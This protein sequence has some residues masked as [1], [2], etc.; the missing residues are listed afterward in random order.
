MEMHRMELRS[1]FARLGRFARLTRFARLEHGAAR[2]GSGRAP[3]ANAARHAAAA[4]VFVASAWLAGPSAAQPAV[5]SPIDPQAKAV[6]DRMASAL[7][8][9]T[10]IAVTAD[11]AWDTVQSDGQKLEFGETRRIA[12]RRPDRLRIEIDRRSGGKRG[13]IYDG[14][15]I[16]AFDYDEKAYAAVPKTG[17]V[18]EVVDYAQDD[19]GMRVPL[20][21]LLSADL[22]QTLKAQIREASLV[23]VAQVGGDACDHVAFRT[24]DVD[25][26][27]WVTQGDAPRARRI[28]ITYRNELGQP[29]FR[30]D[31]HD[32]DLAASL[33]DALFS[34]APPPGSERIPFAAQASPAPG[35][36]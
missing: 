15:Q 30:A 4:A 35:A 31:L 6:L 26:Q 11:L 27:V 14:K 28:V 33:P 13:T 7:E 23:D 20:A 18:D 16:A 8:K 12:L 1:R 29:Q 9:A 32:W 10:A 17:T 36:R 22:A 24:D 25:V 21:E 3:G 2:A 5:A 34:I 19:L